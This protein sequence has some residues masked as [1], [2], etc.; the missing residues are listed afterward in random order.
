[1]EA[2]AEVPASPGL[3]AAAPAAW[4]VGA[5][6]GNWTQTKHISDDDLEGKRHRHRANDERDVDSTTNA[7]TATKSV[8]HKVQSS[9]ATA[10]TPSVYCTKNRKEK[11]DWY[12]RMHFNYISL[13][14]SL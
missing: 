2:G 3:R 14:P 11:K 13:S 6:C 5:T 9:H 4:G 7:T 12:K 10:Q 1:M 8:L